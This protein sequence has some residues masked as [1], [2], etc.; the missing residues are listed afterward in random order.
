MDDDK[1]ETLK[2]ELALLFAEMLKET[3]V[4]LENNR[5]MF[6]SIYLGMFFGI[7][8]S[9]FSSALIQIL[10]IPIWFIAIVSGL[11]V[12]VLLV[13][14]LSIQSSINK[15]IKLVQE[16]SNPH[17]LKWLADK[18]VENEERQKK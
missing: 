11:I 12:I 2:H 15:N 5:D 4:R 14:L 10:P 3:K 7:F 8:V 16:M 18:I 6:H 13:I 17:T 9:I 1:K